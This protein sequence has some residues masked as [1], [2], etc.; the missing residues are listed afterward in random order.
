MRRAAVVLSALV[1]G[2]AAF[3]SWVNRDSID[4]PADTLIE[5]AFFGLGTCNFP[6]AGEKTFRLERP[7]L[8]DLA[9]CLYDEGSLSES[10]LAYVREP[11][12]SDWIA[13][14]WDGTPRESALTLRTETSSATAIFAAAEL[15]TGGFAISGVTL[16]LCA[17]LLAGLVLWWRLRTRRTGR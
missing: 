9:E 5:A 4:R 16:L 14:S 10:G 2:F 3:A 17:A 15:S 12:S 7:Q 1:L 6:P 11:A 13:G 8:E